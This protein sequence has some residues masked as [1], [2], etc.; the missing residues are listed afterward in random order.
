[1]RSI[2]YLD[3]PSSSSEGKSFDCEG[4]NW[5]NTK[6]ISFESLFGGS[7]DLNLACIAKYLRG[8]TRT[9]IIMRYTSRAFTIIGI[10]S[11]R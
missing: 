1:M 6:Y 11:S 10:P 4:Q 9:A 3:I 5:K 7:F 2:I 8:L